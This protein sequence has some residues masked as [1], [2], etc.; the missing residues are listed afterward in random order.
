ALEEHDVLFTIAGTLGRVG[1]VTRNVLPAN[2][3]QAVAIVRL[4]DP[5]LTPYL[6]RY[7]AHHAHAYVTEGGRGTGLQNLN[8]LQVSQFNIV[9][10][11]LAEQRRIVGKLDALNAKSA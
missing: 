10:P 6:A 4:S 11:P 5:V 9:L 8:L 1:I 2:T 3:N 7:L